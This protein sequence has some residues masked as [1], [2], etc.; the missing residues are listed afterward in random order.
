MLPLPLIA[1]TIPRAPAP[2]VASPLS[3]LHLHRDSEVASGCSVT[4]E[5]P[6]LPQEAQVQVRSLGFLQRRAGQRGGGDDDAAAEV[7]AEV[8]ASPAGALFINRR[9]A[10]HSPEA[11]HAHLRRAHTG[12]S[13]LSSASPFSF[14]TEPTATASTAGREPRT[15]NPAP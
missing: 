12:P 14:L 5:M 7:A 3:A 9:A 15:A 1:P 11:P 2:A 6:D 10:G 13:C 4:R 8:A